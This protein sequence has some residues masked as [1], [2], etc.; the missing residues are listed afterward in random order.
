[1]A[2]AQLPLGNGKQKQAMK[3]S[4]ASLG[5]FDQTESRLAFLAT[6]LF[7]FVGLRKG[8][9][10]VIWSQRGMCESLATPLFRQCFFFFVG[11]YGNFDLEV[12]LI[13]ALHGSLKMLKSEVLKFD[14]RPSKILRRCR[15]AQRR[16][17]IRTDPTCPSAIWQNPPGVAGTP[18]LRGGRQSCWT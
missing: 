17:G 3:L 4:D 7:R 18:S 15:R 16:P 8:D 9:R 1:M 11:L 6:R 10:W 13:T 2:A 12:L 14:G 5:K